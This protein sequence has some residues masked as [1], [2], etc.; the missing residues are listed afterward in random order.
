MT[1]QLSVVHGVVIDYPLPQF[2][3]DISPEFPDRELAQVLYNVP[4]I[5]EPRR[6]LDD[7]LYRSF[8][9]RLDDLRQRALR[10]AKRLDRAMHYLRASFS[11]HDPI[12]QFEDAWVALE[13]INPLIQ[14]KYSAPT[15]YQPRCAKCQ[16]LLRCAVCEVEVSA[17]DSAS[18]IDYLIQHILKEDASIAKAVRGKRNDI[19]HSRADF[20]T[21]LKDIVKHVGVAQRAVVAGILDLLELS[22][23]EQSTMLRTMLPIAGKPQV[24]V[25]CVL[26][27][28]PVHEL[29]GRRKYPQLRLECVECATLCTPEAHARAH[30]P[31]AAQLTISIQD[32]AGRW[33]L[34]H[35]VP[36]T[37]V[38][39]PAEGESTVQIIT[40]QLSTQP[41]TPPA[42]HERQP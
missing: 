21:V 39:D 16:H 9:A 20:A 1:D 2:S 11:E 3:I 24:V 5:H 42:E 17:P 34:H 19:V 37:V 26:Y 36:G 22:P 23:E 18:G 15:S 25:S 29:N 40:R 30:R 31:M 14:R 10:D 32:F 28:L 33:K 4:V 27:D 41:A 7:S 35:E 8:H 13:S 6:E 38:V 12:D